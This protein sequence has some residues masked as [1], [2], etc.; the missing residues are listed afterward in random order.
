MSDQIRVVATIGLLIVV[1]AFAGRA[2]AFH[3]S[4][5]ATCGGCHVIHNTQDG[6]PII[7]DSPSGYDKLLLY[8]TATDLCLSCHA[9]RN[10][11]V[12]G[13]N[14]TAPPPEKGA[15]NFTFLWE[16]NINDGAGG[17]LNPIAGNHAGHNV[18][19]VGWG[20]PI[21]PDHAVAPGGT[22]PAVDLACT[23]CHDPHGNENFRMLRG[24]GQPDGSGFVFTYDAPRGSGI[25]FLF[26]QESPTSHTAYNQG[27]TRWCANCHGFFHEENGQIFEH[28]ADR[29]LSGQQWNS[30]NRYNGPADPMGGDY[31]TAYLP[32]VPIEDVG[33]TPSSTFGATISSRVICLSCHRAHATS[34]PKSLRWD[35]N[36]EFLNSDGLESESYPLPDPYADPNQRSLCVKCHWQRASAHGW[37]EP[38]LDC[39]R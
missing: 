18:A 15:G 24:A 4:G 22:Y 17:S 23:S 39:H 26:G 8:E 31:A 37:G 10:G 2:W 13:A 32:E 38:C 30:Y 35:G 3:E 1:A 12:L 28:P 16:D 27:W 6:V 36:I 9:T 29:F 5:V 11:E 21:D 19:S 33:M 34:A 7:P 25:S 14:P 20:I